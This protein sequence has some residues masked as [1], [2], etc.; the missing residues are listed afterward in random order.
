MQNRESRGAY[1]AIV[2]IRI[3]VAV[4]LFIHGVARVVAG[5]VVPFG[6]F[7]ASLG[8]PFGVGLAWAVTIA[9]IVGAP[10]LALGRLTISLSLYFI[11]QL[12]VGIALV[13]APWGWFVVGLG[14]NGAEYSALLIACLIA[15]ILGRPERT[16]DFEAAA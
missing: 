8:L 12:L 4:L 13:H 3:A 2:L 15:V 1:R 9:E 10:I 7:F 14:R 6:G 5:A 16:A 11:V